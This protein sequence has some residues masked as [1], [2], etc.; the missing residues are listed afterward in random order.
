MYI[1]YN[2]TNGEIVILTSK[3][4]NINILLKK[5][6][7][8]FRSNLTSIYLDNVPMDLENYIIVNDRFTKRT[9]E[10]ILEIQQ[11][12]KILTEEERL[13]NKLKP[14]YEEIKKAEN[15]IEILTLMQEVI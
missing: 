14:S 15:T 11:Y 1:I 10:E 5:Y 9:K 7:K 4:Q 8:E 2:K 12:G 6:P 3:K 13:L